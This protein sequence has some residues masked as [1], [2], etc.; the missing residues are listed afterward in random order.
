MY[1]LWPT[2]YVQ[3][4]PFKAVLCKN[5]SIKLLQTIFNLQKGYHPVSFICARTMPQSKKGQQK[6]RH[7]RKDDFSLP[8]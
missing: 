7:F 5:R 3:T 1:C 2:I 4:E 6:G 8:V